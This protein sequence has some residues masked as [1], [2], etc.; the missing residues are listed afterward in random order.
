MPMLKIRVND[1][2]L[3]E[4]TNKAG[5]VC[6]NSK[7]IA[8]DVCQIDEN[9]FH[10]LHALKSYRI[11]II[12]LNKTNKTC[13]IQVNTNKYNLKIEDR[14]DLLLQELGI[15]HSNAVKVQDLKAPMPG[16][17]LKVFINEGAKV[18]KGDNLL[19]LEAM[20]MENIIKAPADLTVKL[21]KIKSGDKVEKNQIMILFD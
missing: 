13:V 2:H 8:V 14:F 1:Q 11:K 9:T 16:M 19:I 20:K 4:T 15:S 3:F 17:V 5:L 7:Q 6:V 12:E 18:N 10:V 21:L